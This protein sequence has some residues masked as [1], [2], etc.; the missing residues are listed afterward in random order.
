MF[1]RRS[2]TCHPSCSDIP[3]PLTNG[4]VENGKSVSGVVELSRRE[5]LNLVLLS[6]V[7]GTSRGEPW[8][9]GYDPAKP[10]PND[11]FIA[12]KSGKGRVNVESKLVPGREE[13]SVVLQGILNQ[14]EKTTALGEQYAS[15]LTLAIFANRA[16]SVTHTA[17]R[18]SDLRDLIARQQ[19]FRVS[20]P[21][22]RGVQATR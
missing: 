19:P 13:F 11:G 16:P 18:V 8:E 15:G 5:I 14:Y 20:V 17:V 4:W 1:Q 3:S 2:S 10:H 7:A 12:P 22:W 21:H 6:Y 9:A